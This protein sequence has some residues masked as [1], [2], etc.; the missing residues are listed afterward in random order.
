VNRRL[1][2]T[3]VRFV[4]AA[5]ALGLARV[6]RGAARRVVLRPFLIGAVSAL[7]SGTVLSIPS[8]WADGQGGGVGIPGDTA[9]SQGGR[10]GGGGVGGLGTGGPQGDKPNPARAGQDCFPNGNGAM[11]GPGNNSGNP[12]NGG[13]GG[14]AGTAT[15]PLGTPGGAVEKFTGDVGGGGGCIGVWVVWDGASLTPPLR[16]G[17]GRAV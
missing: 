14:T 17:G 11:G 12:V 1:S 9:G 15:N 2:E 8:V 7:L 16:V 13:P 3:L 10:G 6:E 5:L 4:T